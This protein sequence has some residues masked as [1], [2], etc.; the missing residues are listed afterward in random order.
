M[1]ILDVHSLSTNILLEENLNLSYSQTDIED[2]LSKLEFKRLRPLAM[3]I[4]YFLFNE[5]LYKKKMLQLYAHHL[6]QLLLM[7]FVVYKKGG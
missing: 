7:G 6:N 3:K 5:L 1:D 2:G 4:S